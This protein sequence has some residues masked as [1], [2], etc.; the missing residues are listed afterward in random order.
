MG[1]VAGRVYLDLDPGFN[2][3]WHAVEGIDMGFDGH[4]RFVTVGHADRRRRLATSRPAAGPGSRRCSRSC[5][6]TGRRRRLATR[7]LDD[8]R[9]LARLRLDRARRRALRPEGPLAARASSTCRARPASSSRSRSRS[10][11]ARPRT[12]TAL[13]AQR[14][15]AARARRGGR[16]ADALPRV[17]P[18]SGPSSASPRAAMCLALRLVQRPQRLLPRVGPAGR[19]AGH[20]LRRSAHRRGPARVRRPA[21]EALAAVEDAARRLRRHGAPRARSPRS[22]STP[23]RCSRGCWR[24]CERSDARAG[25]PVVVPD[26]CALERSSPGARP[27]DRRSRGRSLLRGQASRSRSS[28]CTDRRR[29]PVAAA[30]GPRPQAALG[31]R[32]ARAPAFLRDPRARS[33]STA[34]SWRRAGGDAP[35]LRRCARRAST[36]APGCSLEHVS[37]A[38]RSGRSARSACLGGR[39]ALAGW[40]CTRRGRCARQRTAQL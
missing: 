33:R 26:A 15:A 39:R 31:G 9:Q 5:S 1:R 7:R 8:R 3:L 29:R 16:H 14:L 4:D 21:S 20:R 2:Q 37:T 35:R 38:C 19:R 25:R 30:Q 40:S 22:S 10:I 27:R 13:H 23:T 24:R 32:G 18:G 11:P 28:S 17:H 34:T 6:S 12:S 36:G